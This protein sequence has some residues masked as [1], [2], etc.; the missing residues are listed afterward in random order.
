LPLQRLWPGF[1]PPEPPSVRRDTAQSTP[2]TSAPASPHQARAFPP[3]PSP[4]PIMELARYP[5]P[6]PSAGISGLGVPQESRAVVRP[7]LNRAP[8]TKS[9]SW[10]GRCPPAI[11]LD[12]QGT[13]GDG[14]AP[15]G[16]AGRAHTKRPGRRNISPWFLSVVSWTPPPSPSK[17]TRREGGPP[18][19][20]NQRAPPSS[21]TLAPPDRFGP[22]RHSRRGPKGAHRSMSP[23]PLRT[24]VSTNRPDPALISRPIRPRA[25]GTTMSLNKMGP[26]PHGS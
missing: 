13:N 15:P 1:H 10:H 21:S 4:T 18:A 8:P 26:R 12:P 23:G 19:K 22:R 3:V 11:H 17:E 14:P 24:V 5:G 25:A 6:T 16:R 20:P 2:T 7:G 9:K